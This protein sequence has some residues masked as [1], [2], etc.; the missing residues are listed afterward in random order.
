MLFYRSCTYFLAK[1]VQRSIILEIFRV[2]QG[3]KRHGS[4]FGP[5][6]CRQASPTKC[7]FLCPNFLK[8]EDADLPLKYQ[9]RVVGWSV[10][11]MAYLQKTLPKEAKDVLDQCSTDGHTELQL[12]H[13]CFHPIYFLFQID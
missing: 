13:F 11:I 6:Y 1:Q 5:L 12:F 3:L 9:D 10:Q 8:N 7:G 2:T 4:G